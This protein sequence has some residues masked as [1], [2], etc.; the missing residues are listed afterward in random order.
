MVNALHI[1]GHLPGSANQGILGM[2]SLNQPFRDVTGDAVPACR[3]L[4]HEQAMLYTHV[5]ALY[6]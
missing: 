3:R 4:C 6:A 2:L 1:T 5:I